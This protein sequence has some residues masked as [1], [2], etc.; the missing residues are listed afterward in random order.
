MKRKLVLACM[1][2]PSQKPSHVIL[3]HG[4]GMVLAPGVMDLSESTLEQL[5]KDGARKNYLQA[6]H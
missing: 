6:L 3:W 1:C 5:H 2:G 4:A